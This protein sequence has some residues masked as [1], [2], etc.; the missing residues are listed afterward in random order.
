MMCYMKMSS[1]ITSTKEVDGFS[2][3]TNWDFELFFK[4]KTGIFVGAGVYFSEKR[5]LGLSRPI[6]IG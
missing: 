6:L 4:K 3:M 5:N 1:A 2:R